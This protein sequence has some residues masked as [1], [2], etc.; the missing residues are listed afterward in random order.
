MKKKTYPLFTIR[1]KTESEV[2]AFKTLCRIILADNKIGIREDYL[3]GYKNDR[4]VGELVFINDWEFDTGME[5]E[6]DYSDLDETLIKGSLLDLEKDFLEILINIGKNPLNII[7]F[8][9]RQEIE[10]QST[11][12]VTI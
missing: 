9:L 11:I 6:S 12:S 10:Y 3:E 8:Q 2:H 7:T 5:F 1:L 4:K